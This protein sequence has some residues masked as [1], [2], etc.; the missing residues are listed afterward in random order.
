MTQF[1]GKYDTIWW[2]NVSAYLYSSRL[3]SNSPSEN[4]SRRETGDTDWTANRAVD[5]L[6]QLVNIGSSETDLFG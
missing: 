4:D 5:W 3:S 6:P 1:G 2:Q